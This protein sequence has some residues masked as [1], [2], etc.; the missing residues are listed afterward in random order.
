MLNPFDGSHRLL[1]AWKLAF[2]HP[3]SGEKVAFEAPIPSEFVPWTE[4][5]L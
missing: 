4:G 1:H 2:V 5:N 3:V